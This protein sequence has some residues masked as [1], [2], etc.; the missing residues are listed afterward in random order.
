ML[1]GGFTPLTLHSSLSNILSVVRDSQRAICCRAVA[2]V[3]RTC[4]GLIVGADVLL[5]TAIAIDGVS[6]PFKLEIFQFSTVK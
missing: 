6:L 4:D 3:L 2:E 1:L 5:L